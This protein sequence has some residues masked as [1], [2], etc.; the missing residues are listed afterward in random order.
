MNLLYFLGVSRP[1]WLWEW[2]TY[3]WTNRA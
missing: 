1:L 2:S 3:C